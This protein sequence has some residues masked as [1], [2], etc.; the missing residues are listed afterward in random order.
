MYL[1]RVL[2]LGSA[3]A[4]LFALGDTLPRLSNDRT[5][6]A[7]AAETIPPLEDTN[8]PV[9]SSTPTAPPVVAVPVNPPPVAIPTAVRT[10]VRAQ[11]KDDARQLKRLYR[12]IAW[13]RTRATKAA[14][15]LG[16]DLHFARPSR[17]LDRAKQQKSWA[18]TSTWHHRTLVKRREAEH[19][20]YLIKG[21]K[22]NWRTLQKAYFGESDYDQAVQLA[23]RWQQKWEKYLAFLG[24]NPKEAIEYAARYW[25]VSA[26]WLKACAKSEGGLGPMK[27]NGG[28]Y[29]PDPYREPYTFRN[30]PG[31]SQAYGTMQFMPTTFESNVVHSGAPTP[32]EINDALDQ[33]MTAAHM[34]KT[35]G[36][37]QWMG[38]GC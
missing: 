14:K 8:D 24:K 1:R 36:S 9:G 33:A 35:E 17:E 12:E 19:F 32:W 13:W 28:T 5:S 16:R 4:L 23:Q 21:K 15:L 34:F 26:G 11:K 25:G 20:A 6:V 29:D 3:L 27:W 2:C 30:F 7:M 22:P 37:G 18:V 38:D 31:R 10:I